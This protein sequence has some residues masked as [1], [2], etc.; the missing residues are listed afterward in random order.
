[1]SPTHAESG[2]R[3]SI[4]RK[5]YTLKSIPKKDLERLNTGIGEVDH[6]L[7]GGL[8]PGAV[9]LIAGEPGIGKSTL[10]LQV[11]DSVS[12]QKDAQVLYVSGEESARQI[13]IRADRMGVD[14]GKILILAENNVEE[15]LAQ[16]HELKPTLIIIDSIQTMYT[17][18]LTGVAGSIGQ[19]RES[20]NEIL[21][22]VKSLHIPVF[23]I[24]HVTKE[25]A[26]AGPKVLEHIV[27][28]VL[29]LEGDVFHTYRILRGSKNR[30]GPTSEVGIFEMEQNGMIEVK[31]PSQFFLSENK[32]NAPGSVTVATLEGERPILVEIQAL[33]THTSLAIPRRT[34]SGFDYN[35]LLVLTA[36]LG[37]RL[38]VNLGTSDIYVNVAGGLKVKEPSI[39]LGVCLAIISSLKNQAIDPKAVVF[40]EVGLLGEV[41]KVSRSEN[42]IKEAKK[43]GFTKFITSDTIGNLNQAVAKAFGE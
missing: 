8:V 32:E 22:A 18:I 20:A 9:V 34:A 13:K 33:V 4:D 37:K 2:Q 28:V 39:D 17:N 30:F 27:D 26:L 36:V 11:A 24:G 1:M 40:G 12:K 14:G 29:H 23:L 5:A 41:R 25:G 7:G 19:V 16:I 3:S 15:V 38:G 10:L 35:R 42:R 31:N 21:K 6:V 43:L